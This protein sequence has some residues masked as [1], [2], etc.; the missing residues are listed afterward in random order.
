MLRERRAT[1]GERVF[2]LFSL[3]CQR[4]LQEY[5]V[6][7]KLSKQTVSS[8]IEE[9]REGPTINRRKTNRRIAK[10]TGIDRYCTSFS[11]DEEAPSKPDPPT[12]SEP[13]PP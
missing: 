11:V 12:L 13:P 2:V 6:R 8:L 1:E 7:N 5:L 10:C 4:R 3:L 9:K